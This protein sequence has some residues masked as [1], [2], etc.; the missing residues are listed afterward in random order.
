MAKIESNFK[1]MLVG[2]LLILLQTLLCIMFEE[3]K[4]RFRASFLSD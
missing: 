2:K 4:I 3:N 1:E